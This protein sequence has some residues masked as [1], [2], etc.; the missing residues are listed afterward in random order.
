MRHHI[1]ILASI[2][3]PLFAIS[4][5]FTDGAPDWGIVQYNWDGQFGAGVTAAD[6]NRDGWDDLT[7]GNSNGAVRTFM[8]TGDGGF[9]MMA[10]PVTQ[11]AETKAIQWVDID[12]DYDLD[13]FMNDRYG[14]IVVLENIGDTAFVD[15]T[16][17]TSLMKTV[18]L[19]RCMLSISKLLSQALI[20]AVSRLKALYTG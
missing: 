9:E 8:N 15:I 3:F 5:I 10:L 12:E 14:R 16:E 19:L 11:E 6:W 20:I 2:F 4:Q 17:T 1:L 7:F 13:F 18:T